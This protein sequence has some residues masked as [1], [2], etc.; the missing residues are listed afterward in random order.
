MARNI[1]LPKTLGCCRRRTADHRVKA[2][3][4]ITGGIPEGLPSEAQIMNLG[5]AD[6]TLTRYG[7]HIA[8][9]N[10]YMAAKN[11]RYPVSVAT[12]QLF[13]LTCVWIGY[14]RG[15]VAGKVSTL[16]Q[17][18]VN[19]EGLLE[20]TPLTPLRL[21]NLRRRVA[22]ASLKHEPSKAPPFSWDDAIKSLS[23]ADVSLLI[24]WFLTGLRAD[25]FLAI[26]SHEVSY[27]KKELTIYVRKD[28]IK[29]CEGRTQRIFCTCGLGAVAPGKA[30]PSLDCTLAGRPVGQVD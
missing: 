3:A 4:G 11:L 14:S 29:M 27:F 7:A 28:K 24:I 8:V 1:A 21:L 12:L 16:L 18:L 20:N 23:F 5:L 10:S 30:E 15:D 13:F 2:F 17:L 19:N 26:R 9:W 22:D 25:S 6:S